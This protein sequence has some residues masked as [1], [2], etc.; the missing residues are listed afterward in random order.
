MSPF[1]ATAFSKGVTRAESNGVAKPWDSKSFYKQ[2]KEKYGTN[3]AIFYWAEAYM[4]PVG[5]VAIL[6]YATAILPSVNVS[7]PS[8]F[9]SSEELI[10]RGSQAV[11]AAIIDLGI[12]AVINKY[13]LLEDGQDTWANAFHPDNINKSQM[14]ASAVQAFVDNIAVELCL[15]CIVN[16]Y[17]IDENNSGT[18]EQIINKTNFYEVKKGSVDQKILACYEG[19]LFA[20]ISNGIFEGVGYGFKNLK[21]Y[22]AANPE[23][24]ISNLLKFPYAKKFFPSNTVT[25]KDNTVKISE[26]VP[27]NIKYS[28]TEII[29]NYKENDIN[30]KAKLVSYQENGELKLGFVK[31]N[32]SN[33]LSSLLLDKITKKLAKVDADKLIAD[34]NAPN[35]TKLKTLFEQAKDKDGLIDAWDV[36]SISTKHRVSP[37]QLKAIKKYID[38]G[39]E[40][41]P[42]TKFD[43]EPEKVK[44]AFDAA[45]KSGGKT[46]ADNF[47]DIKK[48][49]I[50]KTIATKNGR[51]YLTVEPNIDALEELKNYLNNAQSIE[52]EVDGAIYEWKNFGNV[53]LG[54]SGVMTPDGYMTFLPTVRLETDMISPNQVVRLS[55][56]KSVGKNRMRIVEEGIVKHLQQKQRELGI[57]V[58][59]DQLDNEI[60]TIASRNGAHE[61][62]DQVLKSEHSSELYWGFSINPKNSNE[63]IFEIGFVSGQ[64]HGTGTIGQ[65]ISVGSIGRLSGILDRTYQKKALEYLNKEFSNKQLILKELDGSS[66]LD[67]YW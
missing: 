36:L 45:Y 8:G 33:L 25:V 28:D 1:S 30:Q 57:K 60:L 58:F 43:I 23:K 54:Y 39:Y 29:I 44:R 55:G 66:G 62:G 16:A 34:L 26:F 65:G 4:I 11:V 20:T 7:L 13:F 56:E 64:L 49:E 5:E 59:G 2:Y 51:Q 24:F 22:A 53:E 12:Q 15:E 40:P 61:Q 63:S 32:S 52:F 38:E 10:R 21:K 46:G 18:L 6:S 17:S 35:N 67:Y 48:T 47:I 31:S 27:E 3:S 37:D 42:G 50:V 19:M 41:I 14:S 9:L